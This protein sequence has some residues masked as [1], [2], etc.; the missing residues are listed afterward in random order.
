MSSR[1][2]NQKWICGCSYP[3][4]RFRTYLSVAAN[5]EPVPCPPRYGGRKGLHQ[6][7]AWPC[8]FLCQPKVTLPCI[9]LRVSMIPLTM[10]CPEVFVSTKI[11]ICRSAASLAILYR[12]L[13]RAPL[14]LLF[15]DLTLS[16]APYTPMVWH[17]LHFS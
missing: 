10:F 14:C 6:I 16:D 12:G 1:V 3:I 5:C 4:R 8:R 17:E 13:V 15:Q 11:S 9:S 2:V 7:G